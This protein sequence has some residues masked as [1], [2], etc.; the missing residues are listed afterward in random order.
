MFGVAGVDVIGHDDRLNQYSHEFANGL[1]KHVSCKGLDARAETPHR[2]MFKSVETVEG[3]HGAVDSD[4]C[5]F[6]LQKEDDRAW[7]VSQETILPEDELENVIR[8]GAL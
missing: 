8:R 1:L 4:G 5:E 6:I 7:R 3:S 2:I